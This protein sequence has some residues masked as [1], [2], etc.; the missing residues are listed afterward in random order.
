[1]FKYSPFV[2]ILD[3]NAI[4][5]MQTMQKRAGHNNGV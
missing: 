3:W 1:M 5:I 4:V 2:K